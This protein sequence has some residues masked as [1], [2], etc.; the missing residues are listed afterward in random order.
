VLVTHVDVTRRR[1][2]EE[3]A[4]R[5]RDELAHVLRTT[6]LGEL[7]GSLA[8]EINQP[9][10]AIVANAQATR[11]L[12]DAGRGSRPGVVD[13]L[14][15]I[16]ADARRASEV[17]RRLRALFRKEHVEWRPV[18]VNELVGDVV[19]LLRH[20]VE[21]RR[22]ALHSVLG[23]GLAP[24]PG[25]SVQLQQVLLN[26][27]VNASEAIAGLEDGPREIAIETTRR[28]SGGVAIS[29]RDTGP[30][31]KEPDLERIFEPFVSAK[32]G[33]LGMGLAISRSIVEA[34]GG[35]IWA[36]VNPDRGLTLH[37]DLPA[38]PGI[39]PG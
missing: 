38:E 26:L 18:D 28:D 5:Q 13:A 24:I 10:A 25:D 1:Q 19:S 21:R 8:H 7:A 16:V 29:I 34:H 6:T 22:V 23:G 11:R 31:V 35:R 2:A 9:L 15:D 39:R 12:L 4:Q 33:G 17:I 30:G 36:T 20:D 32:P 14:A 3:E 27:L 37:V